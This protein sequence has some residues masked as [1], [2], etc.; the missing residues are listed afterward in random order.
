MSKEQYGYESKRNKGRKRGQ[1]YRP[2]LRQGVPANQEVDFPA[3]MLR[4]R[5]SERVA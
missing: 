5:D 3:R 2:E 1:V 4:P